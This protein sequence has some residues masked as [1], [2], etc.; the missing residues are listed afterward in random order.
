MAPTG[1]QGDQ[2]EHSESVQRTVQSEGDQRT[3]RE[4]SEST[5][6]LESPKR[7]FSW[8]L[9]HCVLFEITTSIDPTM[10]EQEQALSF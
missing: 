3:V 7:L 10:N 2:T 6:D 4:H 1:A 9:K 5:R 8:S